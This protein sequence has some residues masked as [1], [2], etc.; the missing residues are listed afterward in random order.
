[1]CVCVCVD[2]V[3]SWLTPRGVPRSPV[4]HAPAVYARCFLTV[5]AAF[6]FFSLGFCVCVFVH[7]IRLLFLLI[8]GCWAHCRHFIDYFSG[9]ICWFLNFAAFGPRRLGSL[10]NALWYHSYAPLALPPTW[11][12]LG[13]LFRFRFFFF[14]LY[15]ARFISVY[16]VVFVFNLAGCI[17]F[18]AAASF[19]YN[20]IVFRFFFPP[21]TYVFNFFCSG[22]LWFW[23]YRLKSYHFNNL[24]CYR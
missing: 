17:D 10:F 13:L 23:V 22:C 14:L 15:A 1:M 19:L 21:F 9:W 11:L 12:L 16:S 6:P 7:F 18:A 20:F 2:L 8:L 5:F 24:K 4:C 3:A